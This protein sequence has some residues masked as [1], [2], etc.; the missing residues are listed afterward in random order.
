VLHPLLTKGEW[1][2]NTEFVSFFSFLPPIGNY[3]PV[4]SLVFKKRKAAG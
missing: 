1:I 4:Q 3:A 2:R